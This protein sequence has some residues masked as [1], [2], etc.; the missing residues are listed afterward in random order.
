MVLNINYLTGQQFVIE[1]LFN[2]CTTSPSIRVCATMLL[3]GKIQLAAVPNW[4]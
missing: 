4:S 1:G 3:T 2:G